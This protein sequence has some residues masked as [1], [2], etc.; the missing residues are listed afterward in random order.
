MMMYPRT[1]KEGS[2]AARDVNMRIQVFDTHLMFQLA[3]VH[4][5]ANAWLSSCTMGSRVIATSYHRIR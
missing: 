2:I 1:R 3:D 4:G 5:C